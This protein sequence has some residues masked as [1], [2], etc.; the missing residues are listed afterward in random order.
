MYQKYVSGAGFVALLLNIAL[1]T[2]EAAASK[3]GASVVYA[4]NGDY[5]RGSSY[6]NESRDG[7]SSDFYDLY[8][9]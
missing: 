9:Y 6:Y 5:S 8:Q 1:A 4:S 2:P 7:T 3:T